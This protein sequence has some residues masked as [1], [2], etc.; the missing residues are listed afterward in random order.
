MLL[1]KSMLLQ[2]TIRGCKIPLRCPE[3]IKA[4]MYIT[5]QIVKFFMICKDFGKQNGANG[6]MTP[7]G[8]YSD[9]V[10]LLSPYHCLLAFFADKPPPACQQKAERVAKPSIPFLGKLNVDLILV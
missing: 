8:Q 4:K 6:G 3:K 5:L 9:A 2:L 1:V 7:A 10:H